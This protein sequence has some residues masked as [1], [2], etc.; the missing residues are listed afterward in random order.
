MSFI[1]KLGY[2]E[3]GTPTNEVDWRR[4]QHPVDVPLPMHAHSREE[5]KI[6]F[7]EFWKLLVSLLFNIDYDGVQ[8]IWKMK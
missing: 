3:G 5:R 4:L 6:F 7:S 1:S 8:I 2:F